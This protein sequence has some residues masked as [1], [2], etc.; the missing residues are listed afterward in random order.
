M[1]IMSGHMEDQTVGPQH[2]EVARLA[3][4]K[5]CDVLQ[6]DSGP[7]DAMTDL[8]AAKIIELVKSWRNRSRATLQPSVDR[9]V[10]AVGKPRNLTKERFLDSTKR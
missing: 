4:H 9:C 6:L 3:F 7:D 2:V 1:P 8:L 5:A 10:G